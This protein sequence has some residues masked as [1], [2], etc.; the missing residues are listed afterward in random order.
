MAFYS[1]LFFISFFEKN[2]VTLYFERIILLQ[3]KYK[4]WYVFSG[5]HYWYLYGGECAEDQTSGRLVGWSRHP[6][7]IHNDA[8]G[9]SVVLI[10]P[11]RHRQLTSPNRLQ[12][13][14]GD[15]A[16][17]DQG[18]SP[19]RLIGMHVS[20]Y[21]QHLYPRGRGQ[22]GQMKA[23]QAWSPL[24]MA[25]GPQQT[26]HF[27]PKSG[28]CWSSVNDAGPA[29]T[30]HWVEVSSLLVQSPSWWPPTR[31]SA[32]C[33][34]AD[35]WRPEPMAHTFWLWLEIIGSNPGRADVCCQ[36]CA[37]TVLQSVLRP[38]VCSAVYGILLYYKELLR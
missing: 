13:A 36:E 17:R 23:R 20:A 3:L 35:P 25:S 31:V 5:V 37:Y 24:I 32:W 11:R 30:Q 2:S 15:G 6:V 12:E 1:C 38:G 19:G 10:R 28:R 33:H 7:T 18:P 26:G 29:L 14:G 21:G 16:E 9:P 34:V 8:I 4:I 22:D 27:D